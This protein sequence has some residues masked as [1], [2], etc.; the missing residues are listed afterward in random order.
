M[1]T[2]LPNLNHL[3]NTPTTSFP[4]TILHAETNSS[5]RIIAAHIRIK[6]QQYYITR[7]YNP[8]GS[9]FFHIEIP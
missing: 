2:P 6:R 9:S 3:L 4:H 1:N 5:N 7:R 8:N